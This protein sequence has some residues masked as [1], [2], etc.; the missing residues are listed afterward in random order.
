MKFPIVSKRKVW[1]GVSI[2]TTL[3][4]LAGLF[5][6]GLNLSLHFTGGI[7]N[8]YAFT[9]TPPTTDKF[10][11]FVLKEAGAFNEKS[12]KKIDI[13]A[14]VVVPTGDK[15]IDLRY[16][17]PEGTDQKPYAEFNA[18]LKK[19]VEATFQG[20]EGATSTI[21][22]SV[23]NV[24]KGQAIFA[25]I[26][27]CIAIMF[28]IMFSFRNVPK[29]YSPWYFGLATLIAL[30]HDIIILIGVFAFLGKFMNIETGPFFITALLTILGYSVNDSIVVFDRI[31]DNLNRTKSKDVEAVA[32]TSL[33]ET[34][35]RSINTS[36]T[37]L[38]TLGALLFLGS[39]SIQS[40][41]FAL[42]IGVLVGTYS[43]IFVASPLWVSLQL[44]KVKGK[45][46]K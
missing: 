27:A 8:T 34:M 41:V 43:S 23:G 29:E 5:L 46:K 25:T 18:Q 15:G 20:K 16:R 11:E 21:S 37:V 26:I 32:E 28:Y 14:P 6:F 4:S 10:R 1:Y 33:W 3:I 19:D 13:G 12:E 24:L 2:V 7:Q 39:E 17:I 30:L 31:R 35:G 45:K 44:G 38:I 42:F 22:P 40:F 9:S 36:L